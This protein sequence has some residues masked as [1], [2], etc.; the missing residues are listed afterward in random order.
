[1]AGSPPCARAVDRPSLA[2][3]L[4]VHPTD[5]RA[6]LN[7]S[8]LVVVNPPYLIE[9][10]MREWLPELRA[11]LGGAQGGCEVLAG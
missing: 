2:S 1:M 10:G 7:G 8:A 5:S 6:A 3:L 9:E 4:W 11:L